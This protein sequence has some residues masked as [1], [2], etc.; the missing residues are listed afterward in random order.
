MRALSPFASAA[1]LLRLLLGDVFAASVGSMQQPQ[2]STLCDG[3]TVSWADCRAALIQKIFN[4]TTL[5]DQAEP[6]SIE[7]LSAYNMSGWPSPGR[8]V[9]P[10]PPPP[11]QSN[12]TGGS[13]VQSTPPYAWANGLQRLTWNIS[14]PFISLNSTVH[15][16][17]NTSG[18]APA[19]YPPPPS[20]PGHPTDSNPDFASFAQPGK[21]LVLYHNGHETADCTPNY[22]GVVDELNQ[23]GYDVM[24]F[25]MPLI[26]CNQACV[27]DMRGSCCRLAWASVAI[28]AH[29]Y[30][31]DLLEQYVAAAGSWNTSVCLLAV[32]WS[33]A[34]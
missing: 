8:G 18:N 4:R 14:S 13:A 27:R 15:Y 22:D 26:G 19:N 2:Q 33:A 7:L 10:A 12:A 6:N 34:D 21:T 16:S 25:M 20:Q 9:V 29:P 3:V 17:F 32:G 30:V 1:A 28:A 11:S 24:E 31:V 5:P 23:L